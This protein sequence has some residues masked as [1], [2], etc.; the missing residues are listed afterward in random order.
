MAQVHES[1]QFLALMN[2]LV[3]GKKNTGQRFGTWLLC[4]LAGKS[5]TTPMIFFSELGLLISAT[6][7]STKAMNSSYL[8]G[9][10]WRFSLLKIKTGWVL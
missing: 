6:A 4:Y 8:F 10:F 5:Q 3:L 1:Q 7:Y 2:D 9:P